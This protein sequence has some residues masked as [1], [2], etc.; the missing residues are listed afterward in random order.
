MP[1][2]KERIMLDV[3]S[4]ARRSVLPWFNAFLGY[5]VTDKTSRVYRQD[6]W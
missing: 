4:M 6:K 1:V 3:K 2:H 5:T